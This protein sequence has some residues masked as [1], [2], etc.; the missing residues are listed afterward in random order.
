MYSEAGDSYCSSCP[1]GTT[2]NDDNTDCG[3]EAAFLFIRRFLRRSFV[4]FVEEIWIQIL[5]GTIFVERC[6]KSVDCDKSMK[7]SLCICI[8]RGLF[9]NI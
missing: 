7:S 4:C 9:D 6:R 2:S 1:T 5:S 3:K 8:F